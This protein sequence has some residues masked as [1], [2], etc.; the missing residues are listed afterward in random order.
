MRVDQETACDASVLSRIKHSQSTDYANAI[1]GFLIKFRQNHQL[2]ALAG[3][4]ETKS[5]T[6][7]R[8]TMISNYKSSSRKNTVVA[9]ALLI[10]IGFI[11]FTLSCISGVKQAQPEKGAYNL[12][13]LD[14]KPR[15]TRRFP[16]KY[17]YEAAQQGIEGKVL[18]KFV[19]T[20]EG[21]VKEP[22]VVESNPEGV[23][24]EAA[25]EA[26]KQYKFNPGTIDGKAVDCIIRMPI[27][28]E[29]GAGPEKTDS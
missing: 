23:F 12:N 19:L 1:I 4:M 28:F 14:T 22:L 27:V 21:T 25:L 2:P 18:I 26:V 10:L 7:R 13:E 17:P 24:D 8:I 9:F 11:S 29:L 5:Q 20:K 16:P 6:K 3:I 15:V